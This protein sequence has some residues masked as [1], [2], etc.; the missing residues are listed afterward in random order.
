MGVGGKSV[1]GV[2]RSFRLLPA[3]WGTDIFRD[4]RKLGCWPSPWKSR[5][6]HSTG[7]PSGEMDMLVAVGTICK[8]G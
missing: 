5:L 7:G 1:V 4:P 8:E 6:F 2:P 3:V